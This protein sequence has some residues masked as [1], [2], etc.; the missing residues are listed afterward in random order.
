M[1]QILSYGVQV[2]SALCDWRLL[3][4]AGTQLPGT[5]RTRNH[6]TRDYFCSSQLRRPRVSL[7]LYRQGPTIVITPMQRSL[8]SWTRAPIKREWCRNGNGIRPSPYQRYDRPYN[9]IILQE[10]HF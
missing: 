2:G 9:H 8:N 10:S 4:W 6:P 7:L 5:L 1:K 3:H